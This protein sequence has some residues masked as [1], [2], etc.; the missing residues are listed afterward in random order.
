MMEKKFTNMFQMTKLQFTDAF[1]ATLKEMLPEDFEVTTE[2]MLERNDIRV[3]G[4]S[5]QQKGSKNGRIMYAET[6]YEDYKKG[7]DIETLAKIVMKE[8]NDGYTQIEMNM[9]KEKILDHVIYCVANKEKNKERLK[10]VPVKEIEGIT[11]LVI[12]PVYSI[13]IKNNNAAMP[14]SNDMLGIAEI[15]VEELYEAA[16]RNTERRVT[17]MP[18]EAVLKMILPDA[19]PKELASP[20]L[21]SYDRETKT[22]GYEATILGAPKT[23][24]AMEGNFYMIPAS[25]HEFF[26]LPI[27]YENN[28]EKLRNIV[29]Q[30]NASLEPSDI[31]SYN[32]YGWIDGKFITYEAK[33]TQA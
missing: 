12:Y 18:L 29:Q 15:T 10:D 20:F 9:T 14:I 16:E 22:T 30:A 31:L 21:T 2:E 13:R 17:I 1:V 32:V 19:D 24:A 28:V 25:V 4:I 26:F 5:V 23:L 8:L 3:T 33:E 6:L 11:D 7:R 27:G